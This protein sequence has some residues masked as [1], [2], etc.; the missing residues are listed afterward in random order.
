MTGYYVLLCQ[1]TSTILIFNGEANTKSHQVGIRCLVTPR[2]L[3][4]ENAYPADKYCIKN[5]D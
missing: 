5:K 2:G 1:V 3:E 4:V